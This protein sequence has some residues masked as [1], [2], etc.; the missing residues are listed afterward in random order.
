MF[1]GA[2]DRGYRRTAALSA[3][4]AVYFDRNLL[5]DARIVGFFKRVKIIPVYRT[6][7]RALYLQQGH[8][9]NVDKIYRCATFASFAKRFFFFVKFSCIFDK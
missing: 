1:D 6:G 7:L 9:N 3:K 5:Y 4:K 8:G 2:H